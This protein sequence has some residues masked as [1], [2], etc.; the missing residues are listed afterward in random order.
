MRRLFVTLGIVLGV[1]LAVGLIAKSYLRSKA[2]A[3]QV[4]AKLQ[5]A[6]GGAIQ[7]GEADIGFG[8]SSIS[9]VQIREIEKPKEEPWLSVGTITTD[10]NVFSVLRGAMPNEMTITGAKVLLR[11]DREGAFADEAAGTAET[12]GDS[13]TSLGSL[14]E[15]TLKDSQITFRKEG[16]DD[17]VA[18]KVNVTLSR[19]PQGPIAAGSFE[20]NQWGKWT[21]KGEAN[22]AA[23]RVE[24]RLFSDGRV[25]LTEPMLY[26]IPFAPAKVWRACKIPTSETN[27]TLTLAVDVAK[28]ELHYKA[29]M[30]PTKTSV[31]IPAIDFV[32]SDA[33]G[34]VTIDDNLVTL[35]NIEG[36]AFDGKV[37]TDADLDFR[38]NGMTFK[39][40]KVAADKLVMSKLPASW[41]LPKT[42]QGKIVGT[43]SL[44][45]EIPPEGKMKTSGEGKARVVD[46]K[47]AG[48]TAE[49]TLQLKPAPGGFRFSSDGAGAW[50][51]PQ[52]EPRAILVAPLPLRERGEHACMKLR[53][54]S[55][56]SSSHP[57]YFAAEFVR[58]AA[59]GLQDKNAPQ[60]ATQKAVSFANEALNQIFRG[61]INLRKLTEA[62]DPSLLPPQPKAGDPPSYLDL[63]LKLKDIDLAPFVK[64]L[65]LPLPENV[66]AKLSF[67]AKAS[68]PVD[69]ANDLKLYKVKGAAQLKQVK[70]GDLVVDELTTDIDYA[71]GILSLPNLQGKMA[72]Q[73]TLKGNAEAQVAPPGP[74]R[75]SLAIADIPLGPVARAAGKDVPLEGNL[76]GSLTATGDIG[77]ITE[78]AAWT[79]AAS[80]SSPKLVVLGMEIDAPS[81]D[82]ALSKGRASLTGF[83]ATI[84]GTP[85]S[86]S[87]DVELTGPFA[88][89]AKLN[90]PQAD[91]AML[92]RLA[93]AFKLPVSVVGKVGTQATA[94]GTLS[95]LA[96]AVEGDANAAKLKIDDVVVEKAGFRFAATEKA[97]TIQDLAIDLYDGH[98]NGGATI[99]LKDEVA[100]KVNINVKSVDSAA[101]VKSIPLIPIKVHGQIDGSVQGELP[102]TKNGTAREFVAQID[103][104]APKLTVQ[105]VPAE[106]LVGTVNTKPGAIDYKL[107]G[108]TLGGSFELEGSVPLKAKATPKKQGRLEIRNISIARL[109]Q[110]FGGSE[111]VENLQGQVSVDVK[112]T[113]DSANKIPNGS[114][115]IRFSN[116]AW[117]DSGSPTDLSGDLILDDDVLRLRQL[118]ANIGGG[119]LRA[120]VNVNIRHPEQGFFLVKLDNVEASKLLRPWTGDRIRGPLQGTIKGSLGS[121]W[122]G[123]IEA[124]LVRGEV[125]GLGVTQWRIPIT[126]RYSPLQQQGQVT[127][128]ETTAQ[129]AS[130]RATGRLNATLGF[131]TRLEG[132]LQIVRADMKNLLRETF[133]SASLGSGYLTA[134]IVVKGDNVR[135]IEDLDASIEGA[136]SQTQATAIPIL[137]DIAPIL[138]IAGSTTFQRGDM[139]ARLDRG[140]VRVQRLAL[141]GGLFKVFIDGTADVQGRLN[142]NV[143]A[144]TGNL[145]TNAPGFR[146]LTCDSR[147]RGMRR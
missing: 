55:V 88:F 105:N 74:M 127:I 136:F 117:N 140:V 8:S 83:K 17:M 110:T 15:I 141:E 60:S 2:V 125:F 82:L 119:Q 106:K 120:T 107:E 32:A 35:R 25:K 44:E 69:S 135:G 131:G 58:S 34:K 73:G 38:G 89:Q 11:F 53:E 137:G 109:V 122:S 123:R 42:V 4:Q 43:A 57:E 77:K 111:Q 61:R 139:K 36:E 146:L 7:V 96:F 78:P 29:E 130:G 13:T 94:K 76:S 97:I 41:K 128:P 92:N 6:I 72:G 28:A 134:K 115:V 112:F 98:V 68:I 24:V 145:L 64:E 16:S 138:G 14:P 108:K 124:E 52:P 46:A 71:R 30:E 143:V 144:N 114:G 67:Q 49:I 37:S 81:A 59:I 118:T 93:P 129:L 12:A 87:A 3:N 56:F 90:V 54:P 9:D 51:T 40:F 65:G 116:V 113:H 95:P 47:I 18:E 1:V 20:A 86:A 22:E 63:N 33:K 62:V 121:E 102:A 126:F 26:Q 103:L 5:E 75:F 100:G 79:A 27:C 70:F 48:Q 80:F 10:L 91:L 19:S 133:G 99:P 147:S 142:L 132:Q 21:A 39:F 66:S 85:M 84:E 31:E 50:L 23:K 45:I 101:L 104:Q